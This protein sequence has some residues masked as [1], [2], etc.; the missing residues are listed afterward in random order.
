[1]AKTYAINT[2]DEAKG[3][4]RRY[5]FRGM[6]AVMGRMLLLCAS[7]AYRRFLKEVRQ[8]G[9]RQIISEYLEDRLFVGRK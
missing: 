2:Q 3:I 4:L 1:M 8:G 9:V 6:P 5:G 7:L